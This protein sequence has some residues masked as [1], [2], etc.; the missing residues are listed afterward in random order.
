[1]FKE[2][3]ENG[4]TYMSSTLLPVKNVFT[5]R[6]GGC[7]TGDFSSLNF[8]SKL[9]DE[10]DCV[11]ENY[12]RY[13]GLFGVG[14]NDACETKQVHGAAV[15]I[16]TSEDKHQNMSIT[17]Y[18]ADG[19]VTAERGLPLFCFTADC[20]PVLLCDGERNAAAAVHC[21]WR[22]SV[23]DILSSTID[24]MLS[25][26]ARRE[27][28][29][30]ALG[31]SIGKCC[32]ETDD[33]VPAAVFDYIGENE[34]CAK[35]GEKYFVDLRLANKIRLMQLGIKEENIDLSSECTFCLPGKYYSHRYCLKN[36]IKR[37]SMSAGIM[38]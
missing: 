8:G 23:L 1:M 38:L 11:R 30:A 21:G 31:P 15:R 5:T 37:G 32:F 35:K 18:E 2:I 10:P 20:I 34:A 17:P 36:G 7:S 14:E 13:C 25:L 4:I 6:L 27:N 28:I 22:S 9:G 3:T 19:I 33:D 24:A 29:F 12:R 16:V 26:G